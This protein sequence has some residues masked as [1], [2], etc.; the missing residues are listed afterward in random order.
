MRDLT[1]RFAESPARI[2]LMLGIL[3]LVVRV[4]DLGS[5]P[6]GL[7]H[8]EAWN[9]LDEL[10]ISWS[11]HPVFFPN[12][13]GRE[14]LFFYMQLVSLTLLGHN[15]V[16]LRATSAVIGAA[17]VVLS[18]YL[19]RALTR[20]TAVGAV[21]G[22][23][24]AF[25]FWHLLDSRLGYRAILQPAMETASILA[26]WAAWH[27]DK[28][29][30]QA[31]RGRRL[32][33]VALGGVLIGACFY[34]YIAA[35]VFPL[36]LAAW[37]LWRMV[38]APASRRVAELAEW[39]LAGVVAVAVAVPLGLYFLQ[40]PDQFFE[41]A[42]QVAAFE[43]ADTGPAYSGGI[44]GSTLRTLGMFSYK[45]DA[46]WKFNI[47][48]K[49]VFDVAA[50]LLFYAGLVLA[51]AA[52][53]RSISGRGRRLGVAPRL[54]GEAGWL[55][56]AW[57]IVMMVPGFL[58][59]ESPYY[60]RVIGILPAIYVP[61]ACA[62]VAL[63]RR[64]AAWRPRWEPA[65]VGAAALFLV[66]EAALTVRDYFFVW[67]PSQP[68]YEAL[69]GEAADMARALQRL[70]AGDPVVIATDYYQ[71]PTIRFL[72]PSHVP[73]ATWTRGSEVFVSP[74]G[75]GEAIYAL[76]GGVEPTFL[77]LGAIFRVP[78]AALG[79]DP[80]HGEAYRIYRARRSDLSLP[81][82]EHPLDLTLGGLVHVRGATVAPQSTSAPG[83]IGVLLFW[84]P[85]A[86]SQRKVS[87]FTH[88]ED[89][90]GHL[91][92]QKDN[93]GYFSADWQP[94]AE[95]VSYHE[96]AVPPGTPPVAMRLRAGFYHIDDLSPLLPAGI[97]GGWDGIDLGQVAVA[98]VQPAP[99]ASE[100][101]GQ[102]LDEGV[103]VVGASPLALQVRQGSDL[104]VTVYLRVA[105]PV[106]GGK[107]VQVSLVDGA[108]KPVQATDTVPLADAYPPAR[109]QAGLVAEAHTLHV[110]ARAAGGPATVVAQVV[111]ASGRP[112]AG[113]GTAKLGSVRVTELSRSF[114]APQASTPLH[115][116]FGGAFELAG[117]SLATPSVAPG[118]HAK[119][120]L[121]WRDVR[122]TD[123]RYTV[124][125]H[126]V[127]DSG[128][129]RGQHDS[130]P[131]GGAWPTTAWVPNQYVTDEY[132]VPVDA[133][134]PHGPYH[135]ELGLYDAT[136]GARL[137]VA[138]PQGQP[139]GDHV[140]IDGITA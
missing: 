77:D 73:R 49:P 102:P 5:I 13:N 103:A 126:L 91:W 135:F 115:A 112:E 30:D 29:L 23:L 55:V 138:G 52:I 18:F 69:H 83:S 123:T 74:P 21:T 95:V 109:W 1:R 85:L 105:G 24:L 39:T 48:D 34:T 33:L 99:S 124:F 79:R 97:P 93:I 11:N 37:F 61:P 51:V 117:Y 28:A 116:V 101:R 106:A 139:M 3:A 107:R 64:A 78:P 7:H 111:D 63:C 43:P 82:P 27:G 70:P 80:A 42:A 114:A 41:R 14:P 46:L 62:L 96:I 54:T 40:H 76:Q 45:G 81:A 22:V 25:S 128:A 113:S 104:D 110:D 137:P 67:G 56:L 9:G 131:A 100:P 8:D 17:T 119:V 16:A 130:Q 132:T 53:A 140:V 65:V 32:L 88:L 90:S 58:A 6:P 68:A 92:A 15:A 129:M 60:Y 98:P 84:E 127:D 136:T 57:I 89:P 12:S 26:L 120:T 94:G 36:V 4:A 59:T 108:G 122:P 10:Q 71:H 87:I 44:L 66:V 118:G 38:A 19:G 72:A 86:P 125:V 133:A 31:S 47:G 20:S 121:F 134:A 50:S 35:R 2:A 75:D